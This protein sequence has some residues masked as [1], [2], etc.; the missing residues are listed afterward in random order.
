MNARVP[1]AALA[2]FALPASGAVDVNAHVQTY[3]EQQARDL[4][5]AYELARNQNEL[6]TMCVKSNQV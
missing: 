4:V 6:I 3:R 5:G 1:L 2:A